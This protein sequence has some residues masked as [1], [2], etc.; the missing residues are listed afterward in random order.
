MSARELITEH[1]DLWTGA[2]THKSSAGRGRNGKIE[3]T[4]IKKLRELILELAVRGKLVE[5]DPSDEPASMLLERIAEEKARLVRDG[6]IKK[7]KKLP[8]VSED[9]KPFDLPNGWQWARLSDVLRVINGRAYKKHEMLQAGTPLL[10]VGNLFTSSE[11]Y[12]SDLQLDD[13]KYIDQGDLIYA[14]SASFGPFIWDGG[15]AIYHYHIWK[16]ELF[17][18]SSTNKH[19]LYNYLKAVTEEVKSSGSGIAMIHMTKAKM[20]ELAVPLPPHEEQQRIVEKVDELMALCDR[21]EQQVGDQLEAHEV[22]VDTLLDALTRSTGAAEVAENW[23]RIAEHF[24]TLFTTEASIDKLKQTILQ[25]A[26]MG[27]LVEQDPSDEPASVLLE[28]IAEEKTR[29][30]KEGKI[31]KTKKIPDVTED[32]FLFKLP[33]G[34]SWTRFENIVDPKFSISYG[35]LVPGPETKNGVPLVRVADLSVSNPSDQPEKS[36][37]HGVDKK[38]AKTRLNGGEILLCVVGSIGKLGVAPNSWKGA[39]I[40]RAICRIMPTELVSKS[41]ILMLL[42]TEFMQDRFGKDTRTLAQPTL[43]VGL[44]RSASTPLPPFEEQERIVEKVDELMALCDQLKVRL[45]EAGETRVHL[46][47]AVMEQAVQ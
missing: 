34:W 23:A 5:Q 8:E 41:Y 31:K 2:V 24:D 25:L 11:W 36:I 15:R 43:N 12:Y 42:Q 45:G 28:R 27:R 32:D 7:P 14:W 9:E 4:G 10:R 47:E 20:E 46:A 16:L 6:T 22:L 35:V 21:L 30:V 18:Q 3:L 40:A 38:F 44:I 33:K 19:F 1:L 13:D 17:D 39:N 29:L 37:S 26:V